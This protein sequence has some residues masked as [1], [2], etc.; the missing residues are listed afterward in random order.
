MGKWEGGRGVC[1][2]ETRVIFVQGG[3]LELLQLDGSLTLPLP[4]FYLSKLTIVNTVV[5]N[6]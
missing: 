5:L 4:A 6:N 3:E 2:P 1:G